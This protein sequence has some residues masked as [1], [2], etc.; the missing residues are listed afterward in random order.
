MK[1]FASEASVT[2]IPFAGGGYKILLLVFS[3]LFSPTGGATNSR[4]RPLGVRRGREAVTVSSEYGSAKL[5]V[6]NAGSPW[7]VSCSMQRFATWATIHYSSD[8]S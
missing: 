8:P 1:N 2:S 6:D 3:T 4:I 5:H 7:A